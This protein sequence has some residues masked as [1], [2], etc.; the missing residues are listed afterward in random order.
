MNGKQAKKLRKLAALADSPEETTYMGS[1]DSI[2]GNL[3]YVKDKE[4]KDTS[5]IDKEKLNNYLD[6]IK[7]VKWKTEFTKTKGFHKLLRYS[8]GIP[9]ALDSC[10]RAVYKELKKNYKNNVEVA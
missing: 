4:G 10:H 3:P 9:R 7:N 5:V 6:K 8:A 1:R 2:W